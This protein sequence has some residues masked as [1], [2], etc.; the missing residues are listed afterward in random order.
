MA[1]TAELAFIV[2]VKSELDRLQRDL[3]R[4]S[5]SLSRVGGGFS[6]TKKLAAQLERGLLVVGGAAVAGTAM[7]DKMA[8]QYEASMQKI[9]G[10]VGVSQK[11]VDDWSQQLLAL[12][13]QVAKSPQEL[14]DALY[15]IASAGFKGADAISVLDATARAASAGL[16]ETMDVANA[17]TS[18]VNAYGIANLSASKATDILVAAVRDG[19]MPVAALA[20][21]MGQVIPM[22][23]RMGVSFDQVA[24]AMAIVSRTGMDMS[25]AA[26]GL[27]QFFTGL[28]KTTPKGVKALKSVGLTYADLRADLKKPGGLPAVIQLLN[29]KFKGAD[30]EL[31]KVIPNVRA[32]RPLLSI[33]AQDGKTTAGIFTDVADSVGSSGKAFKTAAETDLFKYNQAVTQMQSSAISFGASTL[34]M[35]TGVMQSATKVLADFTDGWNKL[36]PAEQKA[37][38]DDALFAAGMVGTVMVIGKAIGIVNGLVKSYKELQAASL[39]A[40]GGSVAATAGLVGLGVAAFA[41]MLHFTGLDDS[42]G[43]MFDNIANGTPKVT[44]YKGAVDDAT[45][46]LW[47]HN[48][49]LVDGAADLDAHQQALLRGINMSHRSAA[50]TYASESAERDYAS[51]LAATATYLTKGQGIEQIALT[52]RVA[53]TAA[54]DALNSAVATYGKGSDQ[55]N[56][57]QSRLTEA[58]NRAKISGDKLI[59]YYATLTPKQINAAKKAGILTKAQADAAKKTQAH[60][61]QVQDLNVALGDVPSSVETNV[62]VGVAASP[63]DNL[64]A[65]FSLIDKGM[66]ERGLR[67]GVNG[68]VEFNTNPIPRV[69]KNA[70]TPTITPTKPAFSGALGGI[71]SG[72]STGYLAILHGIEPVLPMNNRRRYEQVLAEADKRMGISRGGSVT[73]VTLTNYFHIPATLKSDTDVPALAK[74]LAF[75]TTV[76]LRAAGVSV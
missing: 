24:A 37:R 32:L 56:L 11:Q 67:W 15:Y 19:K 75:E 59:E 20:P 45:W 76:A 51:A 44:T 68:T 46:A 39:L 50:A 25:T 74:Q 5:K 54:Q 13:P 48:Q 35:V 27:N 21:V 36:T 73:T 10:L 18:A 29:D 23:N 28:L 40:N 26:V 57:A 52:D 43:I 70:P 22:A 63:L 7:A 31:V 6:N 17:V 49:A 55:A 41:T 47:V 9:V 61:K 66:K 33:L 64:L 38:I 62:T 42:L 69:F 4:T 58:Q 72:P 1:R 60:V 34:P 14:A 53:S 8:M 71:A 30:T 3:D 16:G 65:Q 12:G 2:S